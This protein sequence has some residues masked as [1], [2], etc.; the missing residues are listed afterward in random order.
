M[1]PIPLYFT[2]AGWIFFVVAYGRNGPRGIFI[3]SVKR[4][5]KIMFLFKFRIFLVESMVR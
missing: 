3:N 2:C 1:V 4:L 5:S